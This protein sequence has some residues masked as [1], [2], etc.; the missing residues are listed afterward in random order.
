MYCSFFVVSQR[1]VLAADAVFV[2]AQQA[3]T[4]PTEKAAAGCCI[5]KGS[6]YCRG[7]LAQM[8]RIMTLTKRSNY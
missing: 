7:V 1:C 6:M 8:V 3:A 2:T 5:S 4:D